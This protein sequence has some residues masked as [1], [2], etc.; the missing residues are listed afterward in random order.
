M[1]PVVPWFLELTYNNGTPA[2]TLFVEPGRAI[3]NPTK[4][5]IEAATKGAP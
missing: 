4:A 3:R 2:P 5:Q 1:R